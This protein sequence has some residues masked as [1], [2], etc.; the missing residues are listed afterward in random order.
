MRAVIVADG[1]AAADAIRQGLRFASGITVVGYADG[2]QACAGSVATAAPDT[3]V[4]GDLAGRAE[5]LTRIEQ[6]RA[7][8]PAAKIVLFTAD[9]DANW[10]GL[11]SAAGI[12]AAIAASVGA[13]GLGTLLR[14]VASGVVFHAFTPT[15]LASPESH[16]SLDALTAREVEILRYAAQGASNGAIARELWVTEQTVKFHLS[17]IYRKLGV[18]NRTQASRVAHLGGLMEPDTEPAG[19]PV[20]FVAA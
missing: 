14:Q 1:R 17:N 8:V 6:L 2:R 12:D 11:A 18:I 5:M 19:E 13:A 16:A 7:A 4:V 10:L 3:V 15:K 20:H 9:M